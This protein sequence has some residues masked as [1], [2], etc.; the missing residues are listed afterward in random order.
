M[1]KDVQIIIEE[2]KER[3]EDVRKEISNFDSIEESN[4]N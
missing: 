3:I 1:I 2:E 4:K